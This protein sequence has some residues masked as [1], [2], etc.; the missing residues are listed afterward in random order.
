MLSLVIFC[1]YFY[2]RE[3]FYTQKRFLP[4]NKVY[5]ESGDWNSKV[6]TNFQP[7]QQVKKKFW[8]NWIRKAVERTP[9]RQEGLISW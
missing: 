3:S 5:A 1:I 7:Q 6:I 2:L 9:T 4:L 8:S